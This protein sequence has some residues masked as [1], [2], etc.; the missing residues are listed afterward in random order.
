[1]GSREQIDAA[2]RRTLY[3]L[4]NIFQRKRPS[5]W[6]SHRGQQQMRMFWHDHDS[7]EVHR[8]IISY[9]AMLQHLRSGRRREWFLSAFAKRYEQGTVKLLI[10]WQF[11]AVFVGVRL[12]PNHGRHHGSFSRRIP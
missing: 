7:M 12:K 10:V 11:P 8:P 2:S 9:E 4:E 5:P 3:E 1:M 6:I